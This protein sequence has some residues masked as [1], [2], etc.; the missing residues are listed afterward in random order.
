VS[1]LG[2]QCLRRLWDRLQVNVAT[3]VMHFALP[4]CDIDHQL[5]RV[6]CAANDAAT[7]ELSLK[8]T[9]GNLLSQRT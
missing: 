1:R 9:S 3:E 7:E 5:H 8:G 6:I 2:N 4:S